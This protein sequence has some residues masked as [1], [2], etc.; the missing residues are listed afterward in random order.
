M[1]WYYGTYSCGH[2]GRIN[3]IGP[4]KDRQ[5]RIDREFS[6][7][8]PE[9]YKEEQ[10][11]KRAA[12][13]AAAAEKSAEM[14]LPELTGSKKQVAWA[15]TLRIDF[16]ERIN[17]MLEVNEKN[18]KKSILF[19]SV[20]GKAARVKNE[21]FE[22]ILYYAMQNKTD[23]K[24]WI[25]NRNNAPSETLYKVMQEYN[26]EKNSD[27]PEEVKDEIEEEKRNATVVPEC[28][29]KKSGVVIIEINPENSALSTK[30]VK[31]FDF[32]EIVKKLGYKWDGLTWRKLLTEYT[33]NANDRAAELGNKLLLSGFTVQFPNAE[34]KNKAISGEFESENDRW[35]KFDAELG[36]LAICWKKKSDTLYNAAKKLTGARWKGGA[37]MVNVEFYQEVIDF[38]ETMGFSISNK[39]Q[40]EIEKYKKKES[41]FETASVNENKE[42]FISD[43]EKIAKSLKSGGT[44][45][46]DLIDE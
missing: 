27:I 14:E 18:G 35:V 9:C 16:I 34:S 33:V 44:I 19:W 20:D 24:F 4:G 2:E 41:G 40:E 25:D 17:S 12:A 1:A 29:E 46:E 8:C 39:A 13:N 7:L 32:I 15:N 23:A 10:A 31:D 43:K 26:D 30:Y 42:D 21:T 11:E 22:D 37:M 36:K 5:W 28:E 3:V 38:A 45:I 6:E